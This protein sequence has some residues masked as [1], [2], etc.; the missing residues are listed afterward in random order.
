MTP[1]LKKGNDFQGVRI[2]LY[3]SKRFVNSPFSG[4]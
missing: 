4:N 2:I 1:V 3:D